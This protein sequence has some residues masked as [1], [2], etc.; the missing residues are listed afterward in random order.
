MYM[1]GCNG[2]MKRDVGNM[3][4][5][6]YICTGLISCFFFFQMG[7]INFKFFVVLIYVCIYVIDTWVR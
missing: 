2:N 5:Y 4:I 6:I 3:N 7:R 1:Y